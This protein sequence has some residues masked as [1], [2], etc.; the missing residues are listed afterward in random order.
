[1]NNPYLACQASIEGIGNRSWNCARALEANQSESIDLP[2]EFPD[3]EVSEDYS[4]G[5]DEAERDFYESNG[6]MVHPQFSL[7]GD[8]YDDYSKYVKK[9]KKV[10]VSRL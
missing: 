9:L 2:I 1:M 7:F 10:R 6:V 5:F 4:S 8:E 3:P